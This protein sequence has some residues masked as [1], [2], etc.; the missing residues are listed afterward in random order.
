LIDVP[1]P[2]QIH[3]LH[4]HLL[5]RPRPKKK[6]GNMRIIPSFK[7]EK[8]VANLSNTH[9]ANITSANDRDFGLVVLRSLSLDVSS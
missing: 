5:H 4:L 1:L 9:C 8:N 6:R 3:H 2:H 7:F